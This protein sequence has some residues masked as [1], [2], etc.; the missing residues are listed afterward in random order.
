LPS[1]RGTT[2][3]TNDHAGVASA[4]GDAAAVDAAAELN[5][6][7]KEPKLQCLPSAGTGAERR[8]YVCPGSFREQLPEKVLPVMLVVVF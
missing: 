5:T 1:G 2:A 6:G 8:V 3:V 7:A 4:A